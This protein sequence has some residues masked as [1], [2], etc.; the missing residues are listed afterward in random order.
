[1]EKKSSD[2]KL[3]N[4]VLILILLCDLFMITMWILYAVGISPIPNYPPFLQMAGFLLVLGAV[5]YSLL[6]NNMKSQ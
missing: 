6:E 3:K 1:M 5:S 4:I 2:K